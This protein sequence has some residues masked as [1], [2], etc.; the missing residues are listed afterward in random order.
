MYE[1]FTQEARKT[2]KKAHEIAHLLSDRSVGPE[3]LLLALVR[4]NGFAI[5]EMM[6]LLN[7]DPKLIEAHVLYLLGVLDAAWDGEQGDKLPLTRRLRKSLEFA[8][9]YARLKEHDCIGTF[10]LLYGLAKVSDSV[11]AHA[12][13]AMNITLEKIDD[14]VTKVK[15]I[16]LGPIKKDN[17]DQNAKLHEIAIVLLSHHA[18]QCGPAEALVK[19]R[20]LLG[21]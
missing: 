21:D 10:H 12:L 19:I 7:V 9:E 6:K 16:I 13:T 2:C 15:A 5:C 18:G 11:A 4:E 3:H 8:I 20:K 14:A 1:K 17:C